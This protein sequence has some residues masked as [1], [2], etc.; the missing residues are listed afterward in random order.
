M[1]LA[2]DV[3]NTHI[4]LGLI[5]N[6]EILHE[7]RLQS[8][9]NA[10]DSEYVIRLS[11]LFEFLKI[12]PDAFKGAIMSSVVPQIT[13]KLV[14]A[15]KRICGF[16]PIVVAPGIKTG[17]N[18]KID[19]PG[20]LAGDLL[21]GGVA[22]LAYYGAPAIIVD[23][24]TATTITI[25]DKNKS[26]IGGAI[27]PGVYLSLNA[28]TAGTSLLPSISVSAT[29]KVIGSNTVDCMRSGAVYANAA[30]IDGMIDRMEAELGYKCNII[31]TGGLS[32]SICPFCTHPIT[33]DNDLLL[34]GLWWLY[35]KNKN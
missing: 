34:K 10:T 32:S 26:F 24:G 25:V 14:D 29:S 17:M 9:R 13:D 19:D 28:L 16:E 31:A 15:V 22:A 5:E 35:N 6:G 30:M 3:G 27:I 4:V 33:L 1:I 11:Q 23:M 18:I 8:D 2:I 21:V 12:S 7:L 20:S